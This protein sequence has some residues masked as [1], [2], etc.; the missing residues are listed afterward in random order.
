MGMHHRTRIL[1]LLFAHDLTG[2]TQATQ[3]P[4]IGDWL[5]ENEVHAQREQLSNT[6]LRRHDSHRQRR[7]I[8][9]RCAG[10]AQQGE[11]FRA[12]PGV[13]DDC[14]K[15]FLGS[16]NRRPRKIRTG[17]DPNVELVQDAAQNRGCRL[18]RAD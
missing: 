1:P 2:G 6:V 14:V 16:A 12:R 4:V 5:V 18:V 10:V 17:L 8:Q 7:L 3:R 11:H 9:P 15:P 13:D